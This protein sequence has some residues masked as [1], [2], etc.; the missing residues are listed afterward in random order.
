[1]A[2]AIG[3]DV[4][5]TQTRVAAI[6]N[7]SIVVRTAFP[8]RG[9]REVVEAVGEVL[10]AAGW[11]Q[12]ATIGVGAP[13]PMDMTTGRIVSFP[14]LPH[15]N[16][17]EVAQPLQHAFRCPVYLA[18]DATCAAIGELAW[19][20]RARDF[21]YL[22]WS[23]GIGGGIVSGGNVVWGATGQ[24]GEIGHIVVRPEGPPC[25]C[26]KRGC[27]EAL[28]GGASLAAQGTE[29]LGHPISARELVDL[30][31]SG[32]P[33][34]RAL[35]GRACRALGQAIAILWDLLEP[36]RIILGGGLT[37]SWDVL[38]PQVRA[39]AQAMTRADP[40]LVLTRLGDDAGLLGAAALPDYVPE[41]W[42]PS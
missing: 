23:T 25:G 42:H 13:A 3:V 4:G 32:D 26:G 14:N 36:E 34:A 6:D 9:I 10:A 12:P 39:A 38:G 31:R 17:V 40:Q 28:A 41:R 33:I 1:M 30:A 20:H 29:A 22:T 21:V 27:L 7:G 24:A 16:G 19:G 11:P 37:R 5:G 18:N 35:V 15:W 8:T 2:R